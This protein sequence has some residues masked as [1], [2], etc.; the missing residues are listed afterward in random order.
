[1]ALCPCCEFQF[2]VSAEKKNIDLEIVDFAHFAMEAFGK[3]YADP[4]PEVQ[5]Q[6]ATFEAMIEVMTPEGFAEIMKSMWPELIRRDADGYGEND[7]RHGKN[8]RSTEPDETDVP[9]S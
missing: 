7:A 4:N 8:T 2:R 1:M 5:R 3:K 6:W 9:Y